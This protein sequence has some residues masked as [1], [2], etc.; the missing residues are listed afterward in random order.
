MSWELPPEP[1]HDWSQTA[2]PSRLLWGGGGGVS[3]L[4]AA[5]SRNRQPATSPLRRWKT[6][7]PP[8][9]LIK[10]TQTATETVL[11]QLISQ[12]GK[13]PFIRADDLRSLS[14]CLQHF[15]G[16]TERERTC[17]N[18]TQG[19]CW[20]RELAASGYNRRAGVHVERQSPGKHS[21]RS[22]HDRSIFVPP[23]AG[24]EVNT[25][26]LCCAPP[27]WLTPPRSS[28][29]QLS[30]TL[31]GVLFRTKLQWPQ[32][33]LLSNT[34]RQWRTRRIRAVSVSVV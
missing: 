4:S 11:V 31:P 23:S 15:C 32:R 29:P 26:P 14:L 9:Y 21:L 1:G 19:G 10:K 33:A 24:L 8:S 12:R 2:E 20:G 22:G 17:R 13:C 27:W 30:V 3:A 25:A 18:K 16:A 34:H 7:F 28:R 6:T 5:P